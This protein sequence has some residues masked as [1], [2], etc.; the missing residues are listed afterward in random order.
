MGSLGRGPNGVVEDDSVTSMSK[1]G[2]L[3]TTSSGN[4]TWSGNI[5]HVL[6]T[7]MQNVSLSMLSGN[8]NTDVDNGTSANLTFI[9]STCS[10]TW[11]NSSYVY[12][13]VRL[14]STY[15]VSLIA[16]VITGVYGCWVVLHNGFGGSGTVTVFV[17]V[18]VALTRN[19][20][21]FHICRVINRETRVNLEQG[22]LGKLVP[23][24]SGV[25]SVENPTEDG[26]LNANGTR[27]EIGELFEKNKI[28]ALL[29]HFL[30]ILTTISQSIIHNSPTAHE[31]LQSIDDISLLPLEPDLGSSRWWRS[32]SWSWS[33]T[34]KMNSLILAAVCCTAINHLYYRFLDG[35]APTSSLGSVIN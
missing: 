25:S 26:S 21:L 22:I 35:K 7:F 24:P 30:T 18:R 1:S 31:F 2:F 17:H 10:S 20:R 33:S 11:V 12:D 8:M 27:K 19:S 14:L 28:S 34:L 29:I 3:I 13:R 9:N 5:T 4:H 16:T 23:A 32:L 6:S 15:G